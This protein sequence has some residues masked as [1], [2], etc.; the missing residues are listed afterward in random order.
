MVLTRRSEQTTET[1]ETHQESTSMRRRVGE[2][3]GATAQAGFSIIEVLIASA[4]MLFIALGIIPLFVTAMSSNV[5]G[6]DSTK[7][8][9]EVR[10]YLEEAWQIPFADPDL[11][12][13]STDGTEKILTQLY[14]RAEEKWVTTLTVPN[15]TALFERTTRI[16]QFSVAE[17]SDAEA[18]DRDPVP[19]NYDADPQAIQ[20]KEITVALRSLQVPGLLGGGKEIEMRAYKTI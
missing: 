2:R 3:S 8:A 12:L 13:T 10:E 18:N 11:T 1:N 19:L 16:R 4:I 14:S 5:S 6:N 9:N 17:L 7:T 20:V 15:D